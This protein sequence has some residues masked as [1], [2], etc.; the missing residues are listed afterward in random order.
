MI[1][2]FYKAVDEWDLRRM[3]AAIS[4]GW[5]QF[6][7]SH[8]V[9]M[10]QEYFPSGWRS[11]IPFICSIII[12]GECLE[13][14]FPV[15]LQDDWI[16]MNMPSTLASETPSLSSTSVS[17]LKTA[18]LKC[19]KVAIFFSFTCTQPLDHTLAWLACFRSQTVSFMAL[20]SARTST[21]P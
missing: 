4:P 10:V 7:I 9:L 16:L 1:G 11:F 6:G 15:L 8:W 13:R 2:S 17:G 14:V 5:V 19:C 21:F 3:R 20:P 12:P 18:N